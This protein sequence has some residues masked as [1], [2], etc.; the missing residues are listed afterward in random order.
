MPMK[1]R[2]N[3]EEMSLERLRKEKHRNE[4]N[5]LYA[6]RRGDKSLHNLTFKI[7][8]HAHTAARSERFFIKKVIETI[9]IDTRLHI[10]IEPII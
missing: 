6:K 1:K 5:I 2:K 8:A 9:L 7:R 3:Y 4:I 10:D